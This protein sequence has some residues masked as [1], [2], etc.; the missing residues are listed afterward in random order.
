MSAERRPYCGLAD[1]VLSILTASTGPAVLTGRP[2]N[3]LVRAGADVGDGDGADVAG[4][5]VAGAAPGVREQ[6][7][8]PAAANPPAN[9]AVTRRQRTSRTSS[10]EGDVLRSRG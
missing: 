1:R 6:A 9:A 10:D 8:R 4:G 3:G 2:V 5:G 7:A